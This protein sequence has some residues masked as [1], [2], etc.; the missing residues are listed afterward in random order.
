MI[1]KVKKGFTLIELV[2]VIAVIAI[3]SAVSVVAYVGITNN[4]KKSSANQKGAQIVTT[5]RA[6]ALANEKGYSGKLDVDA[7]KD[8]LVKIEG[9]LLSISLDGSALDSTADKTQ[10]ISV[11]NDMVKELE[12]S[13]LTIDDYKVA[14]DT[15]FIGISASER[16]GVQWSSF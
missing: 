3:L 16:L 10:I 15:S 8:Y 7:N 4:A 12:E 13:D 5:I 14:N 9:K 6:G 1:K 2:V 11:L